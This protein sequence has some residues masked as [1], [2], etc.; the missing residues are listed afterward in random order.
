MR[1]SFLKASCFKMLLVV[2]CKTVTFE[3]LTSLLGS[4][5]KYPT[6]IPPGMFYNPL[7]CLLFQSL[8][9]ESTHMLVWYVILCIC[10][11][12]MYFFSLE[13]VLSCHISYWIGVV[14][15][16]GSFLNRVDELQWR[17][18]YGLNKCSI[19]LQRCIC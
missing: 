18:T 15:T 6:I 9:K 1:L 14:C 10:S 3:A 2:E 7:H 17:R 5:N 12:S 11:I 4:L 19:S 13:L 8:H 16:E